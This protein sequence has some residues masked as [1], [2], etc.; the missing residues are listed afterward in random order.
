MLPKDCWRQLITIC[1]SWEE[2]YEKCEVF[3]TCTVASQRYV[4]RV[5]KKGGV[6]L[7]VS[8]RDFHVEF[9]KGIDL[10]IVDSWE[11]VC[12]ENTDIEKANLQSGLKKSDVLEITDVLS[13]DKISGMENRSLMFNPMGMEIG[14][15][16]V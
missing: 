3:I 14:R 2:V 1:K 10:N 16:H 7:N 15:A 11:E 6:Y 9:M 8:L 5:P 4:D 13:D 12:R